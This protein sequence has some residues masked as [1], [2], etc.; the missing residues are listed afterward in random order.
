MSQP[1]QKYL[2]PEQLVKRWE[3][4]ISPG[5]LANWRARRPKQGPP[6]TKIGGRVLYP[7]AQVEAWEKSQ[8][9]DQED[10]A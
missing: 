3:G 10:A 5:T 6:H 1:S 2:T 7:V 4:R 9:T 8:T